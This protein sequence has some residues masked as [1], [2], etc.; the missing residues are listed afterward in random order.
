MKLRLVRNEPHVHGWRLSASNHWHT[1]TPDDCVLGQLFNEL[2]FS[3]ED[4]QTDTELKT[5]P[6]SGSCGSIFTATSLWTFMCLYKP[7]CSLRKSNRSEMDGNTCSTTMT[8]NILHFFFQSG[9]FPISVLFPFVI[10]T[11]ACFILFLLSFSLLLLLCVFVAFSSPCVIC[12]MFFTWRH[13]F[14]P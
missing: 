5:F 1:V 11:H 10:V 12:L 6:S 14:F 2:R 8:L 3:P 4:L 7:A 9:A 13:C